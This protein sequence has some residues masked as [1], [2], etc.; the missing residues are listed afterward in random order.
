M[1]AYVIVD[2]DVR[3]PVRYQDY[4]RMVPSTIAAFGGKFVVRGGRA[5]RLEGEWVPK[6]MVVIQFE[7]VE[8]AKE[9]WASDLYAGPKSLRQSLSTAN[10][11]VVEGVGPRV[12]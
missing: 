11:I 2:V 9:W 8:R 12:P 5:E 1:A 3:D 7:S 10:M 6:R 4:I